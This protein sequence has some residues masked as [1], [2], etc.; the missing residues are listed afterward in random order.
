MSQ[1]GNYYFVKF[2][3]YS[4]NINIL[5]QAGGELSTAL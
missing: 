3:D 4:E 5:V 1:S 2:D